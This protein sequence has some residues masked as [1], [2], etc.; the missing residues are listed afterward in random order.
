MWRLRQKEVDLDNRIKGRSRDESS[1]RRHQKDT[2]SLRSTINSHDIDD[3]R[4]EP[5]CSQSRSAHDRRHKRGDEGLGDED[6]EEFL[7]SRSQPLFFLSSP[8]EDTC[9]S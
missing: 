9:M 8:S 5:S 6:I 3:Y 1:S 4:A 2:S 7:H